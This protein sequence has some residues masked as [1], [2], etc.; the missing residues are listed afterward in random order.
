MSATRQPDRSTSATPTRSCRTAGSSRTTACCEG[1]DVLD[2]RLREVGT[3]DLVLGD[4]DSERVFALI[5]AS[6]RARGGDVTAGLIDA[7]RWLAEQRAD[8]RG[9]HAAQHGHRPVGA[10]LP[11]V[12]RAV[13]SGS[14]DDT[15]RPTPIS[16][17]HQA[18][19]RPVAD[20]CVGGR[21][22]CSPP[23]R[24]TMAAHWRLLEPGELIHV[25]AGLQ[26]ARASG[27]AGPAATS[28][29]R[30]G[31]EPRQA[32]RPRCTRGRCR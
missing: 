10:A 15:S 3:D 9:Q 21:R 23:S 27:A 6:I 32:R 17:A 31:A 22:W 14:V 13:H 29:A 7:M 11:G 1:L 12:P 20:I 30:R 18:D 5:T 26:I 19:S 25:D 2:E 4:T 24:W 16:T 28:A 8:L